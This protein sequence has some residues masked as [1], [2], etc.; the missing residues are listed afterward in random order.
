MIKVWFVL[1]IP[2]VTLSYRELW[3]ESKLYDYRE[4]SEQGLNFIYDSS[5]G[6]LES[7]TLGLKIFLINCNLQNCI[8]KQATLIATISI[9]ICSDSQAKLLK[10]RISSDKYIELVIDKNNNPRFSEVEPIK[11][12]AGS[13]IAKQIMIPYWHL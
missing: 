4:L 6:Y 10:Y 13:I 11:Y 9:N 2:S 1:F 5:V 7:N 12:I 3:D 8:K